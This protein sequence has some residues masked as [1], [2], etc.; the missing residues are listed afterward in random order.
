MHADGPPQRGQWL[1]GEGVSAGEG[2]GV[3]VVVVVMAVNYSAGR[4]GRMPRGIVFLATPP[5]PSPLPLKGAREPEDPGRALP[6]PLGEQGR[7]HTRP[8]S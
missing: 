7:R 8:G 3:V 5:H 6:T 2:E 1:K 4:G